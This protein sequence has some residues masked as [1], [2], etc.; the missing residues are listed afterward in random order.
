[1][2]N[3]VIQVLK[4][5]I[6][7]PLKESLHKGQAGRIAV[8]G[9]SEEYT[10]A[11]YYAS[12][13]ALK[14]GA[15]MSYVICTKSASTAIK[16]YTPEIIV[17]PYLYEKENDSDN[18][19]KG[20]NESVKKIEDLLSRL[21]VLVIGPGLGR[22]D[23]SLQI[24]EKIIK[25]AREKELPIV[26]DGDCL[27]LISQKSDLIKGYQHAVLLPNVVEYK[28]IYEAVI[29]DDDSSAND[30]TKLEKL[31]NALGNVTI[32]KKGSVD[33]ISNGKRT[34]ACEFT[35]SNRRSGGQGDIL[36]G[37]T[38]TFIHW[39]HWSLERFKDDN[40]E[41]LEDLILYA[42]YGSCMITKKCAEAAF[43]KHY[44]STTAPDLI[45]CLPQVFQDVFPANTE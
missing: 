22:S 39:A 34:I 2:M 36:A 13:S 45:E 30:Q 38:S 32:V 25:K 33:L 11:P 9:G 16:S 26:I 43:K 17:F 23:S 28:R 14:G 6:V 20:V 21:H 44:R 37:L 31:C 18:M 12:I 40:N 42:A 24:A 35:G 7:P 41:K 27:Y 1:M 5:R 10:G 19:D 8:I 29:K 15:D 3:S 4:N